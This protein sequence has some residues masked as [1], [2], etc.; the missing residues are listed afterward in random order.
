MSPK[1]DPNHEPK[2]PRP[3]KK[4]PPPPVWG[5]GELMQAAAM[6]REIGYLD[7][8]RIGRA[9]KPLVAEFGW[10][11][12]KPWWQQY[13]ELRPY[14]GASGNFDRA[15]PDTRFMSAEDFVRTYRTWERLC[16][17]EGSP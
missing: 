16:E 3:P 11:A 5:P 13:I 15:T 14:Q 4:E 6:Y 1:K 2:A 12:V 8:A 17:P 7:P 9:L 10:A